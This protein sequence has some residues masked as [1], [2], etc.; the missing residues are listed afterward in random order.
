MLVSIEGF[1]Y[2][3]NKQAYLLIRKPETQNPSLKKQIIVIFSCLFIISSQAGQATEPEC[4]VA[5]GLAAGDDGQVRHVAYCILSQNPSA[6]KN[7][8]NKN[9]K[10]A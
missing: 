7:A 4:L 2:S 8:E 3:A 10:S 1:R 9:H 6:A 5:V